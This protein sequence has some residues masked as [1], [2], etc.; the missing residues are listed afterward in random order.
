MFDF[1]VKIHLLWAFF[2]FLAPSHIGQISATVLSQ[3]AHHIETNANLYINSVIG[4]KNKIVLEVK[5][6]KTISVRRLNGLNELR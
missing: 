4:K 2:V 3:S 5:K 1:W 6:C